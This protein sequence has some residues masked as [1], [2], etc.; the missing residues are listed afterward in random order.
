VVHALGLSAQLEQLPPEQQW[1]LLVQRELEVLQKMGQDLEKTHIDFNLASERCKSY[2]RLLGPYIHVP[3]SKGLGRNLERH[4]QEPQD[5]YAQRVREQLQKELN[6]AAKLEGLPAAI[7]RSILGW[8]LQAGPTPDVLPAQQDEKAPLMLLRDLQIAEL[9][10][11]SPPE[12]IPEV[13]PLDPDDPMRMLSDED[14]KDEWN[15]HFDALLADRQADSYK[16]MT[17]GERFIAELE[18]KTNEMLEQMRLRETA[19]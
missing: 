17:D 12:V 5:A 1:R 7:C 8:Y 19:I 4:E 2:K 6:H 16:P 14:L 15:Q 11:R 13:P 3:W 10:R 9:W 18:Q